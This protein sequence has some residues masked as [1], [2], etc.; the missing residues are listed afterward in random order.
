MEHRTRFVTP[1]PRSKKCSMAVIRQSEKF[2]GI[3]MAIP[4]QAMLLHWKNS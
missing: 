3:I 4:R 2:F 1:H